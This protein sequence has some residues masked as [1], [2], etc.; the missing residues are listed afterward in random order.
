MESHNKLSRPNDFE[1]TSI[2]SISYEEKKVKWTTKSNPER[3]FRNESPHFEYVSLELKRKFKSEG[4][5]IIGGSINSIPKRDELKR[6][7]Y[8]FG[9]KLKI[10]PRG[11]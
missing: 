1:T 3:V 7:S 9:S 8:N 11:N 5:L 2:P 4:N 6:T 10:Q